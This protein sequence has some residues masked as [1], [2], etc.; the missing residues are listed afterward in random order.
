[1]HRI[2]TSVVRWQGPPTKTAWTTAGL[3]TM[4]AA[5]TLAV[6]ASIGPLVID[7]AYIA[8]RYVRNAAL[9]HGL[10]YNVGER[11][12]GASSPL[13]LLVLLP[14]ALLGLDLATVGVAM[15]IICD[16][17]TATL[18]AWLG[19]R[20]G[21]G[22]GGGLAGMLFALAPEAVIPGLSGMETPLYTF[23]VVSGVAALCAGRYGLA[24]ALAGLATIVRPEGI[25]FGAAVLLGILW[26]QR[27]LRGRDLLAALG[28]LIAWVSFGQVYY[29][30]PIPHSVLAK[31]AVYPPH[32]DP[33][34]NSLVLLR[35]LASSIE[36]S[37]GDPA[38]TWHIFPLGILVLVG[39]VWAIRR[40]PATAVLFVWASVLFAAF[41]AVNRY[42]FPWYMAPLFP[43]AVLAL[44]AGIDWL[45][46]RLV[47][48]FK[49]WHLLQQ[50]GTIAWAMVATVTLWP[51]AADTVGTAEGTRAALNR[52]ELVYYEVGDWLR[53]VTGGDLGVATVD[54]G[55]LGYAYA[56][57]IIDLAGLTDP[58]ALPYYEDPQYRFEFPH[59]IP[60][61]LFLD[62]R[63]PIL[64]T[65]DRFL[66][67]LQ[68]DRTFNACYA[69]MRT[70]PE[71]DPYYGSLLVF[72]KLPQDSE[73]CLVATEESNRAQE[74][75][76]AG[77]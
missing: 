19:Q 52:R 27:Q 63:P 61:H 71:P 8:F 54:I 12:L 57:P 50:V 38:L 68:S 51:A 34:H 5:T 43:V 64:V 44:V 32:A 2:M 58:D 9:G 76:L 41:A 23:L 24:A 72:R 45:R 66:G 14:A 62:Q 42:L 60:L 29:G 47:E 26:L 70:W 30:N 18:L 25:L 40:V 74:I 13:Y 21:R 31:A 65:F 6:R 73:E 10:V 3:M 16:I 55:A 33:F 35:Y 59:T 67:P 48:L 56:G 1:M 28:P 36:W 22:I 69:V 75:R 20:L 15:G 39:A 77:T 46:R 37:S 49:E 11:V 53:S 7:D 4:A 17:L